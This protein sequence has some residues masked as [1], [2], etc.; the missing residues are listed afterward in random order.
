MKKWLDKFWK[1]PATPEHKHY[2]QC[3][4]VTTR[5]TTLDEWD[6]NIFMPETQTKLTDF[7]PDMIPMNVTERVGM[8]SGKRKYRGNI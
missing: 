1:K 5:Q 6:P 2:C 8:K 3:G 4:G 7:D